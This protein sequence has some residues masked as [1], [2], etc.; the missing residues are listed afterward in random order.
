MLAAL[1][2]ELRKTLRDEDLIGRIGGD[3]FMILLRNVTAQS[4][5]EHASVICRRLLRHLAGG[6]RVSVSLGVSLYPKDGESFEALY[7]KAD[8]ALY[9]VKNAVKNGYAL[10]G[11]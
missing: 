3:E 6:I 4:A 2:A 5:E 1:T 10:Y 8:A 9:K 7:D 11:E